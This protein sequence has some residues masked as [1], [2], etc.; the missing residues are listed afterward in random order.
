MEKLR[1]KTR[2]LEKKFFNLQ[3]RT[4]R[5]KKII[6]FVKEKIKEEKKFFLQFVCAYV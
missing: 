5:K 3:M 1:K 6:L 2:K 4:L